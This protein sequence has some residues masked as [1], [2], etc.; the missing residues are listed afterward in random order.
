MLLSPPSMV[1]VYYG[2]LSL[3]FYLDFFTSRSVN[4]NMGRGKNE[5]RGLHSS[6]TLTIG[7]LQVLLGQGFVHKRVGSI[8]PQPHLVHDYTL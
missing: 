4:V 1:R 7:S 3:W 2:Y 6:R 5:I 8:H